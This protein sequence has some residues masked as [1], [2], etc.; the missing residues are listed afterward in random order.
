MIK[1][2]AFFLSLS[3]H[4][5]SIK[6][7]PSSNILYSMEYNIASLSEIVRYVVDGR[8]ILFTNLVFSTFNTHLRYYF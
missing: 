1:A 5:T 8:G 6:A 3:P 7:H 4:S 2:D